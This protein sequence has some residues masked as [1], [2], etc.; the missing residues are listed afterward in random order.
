MTNAL[1]SDELSTKEKLNLET[2][3]IAW[4]ELQ[5]FFAQGKL[6]V[7]EQPHD[8][9]HVASLIADNDVEKLEILIEDHQVAFVTADWIARNCEESTQLWAV[10]VSPYVIAQ[11]VNG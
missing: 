9:V 8:L 7:V 10:V 3:T 2:A 6:L 11:L 1:S 4:N 5:V